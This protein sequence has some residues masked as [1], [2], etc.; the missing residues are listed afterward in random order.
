MNDKS[1]FYLFSRDK[2][3]N[4]YRC[5]KCGLLERYEPKVCPAC[6]GEGKMDANISAILEADAEVRKRNRKK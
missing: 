2:G 6:Q 5:R 1:G 3:G 4:W